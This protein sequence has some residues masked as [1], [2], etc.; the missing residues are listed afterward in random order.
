ME[1]SRAEVEHVA[2][3]AHLGLSPDEVDE[4][5]RE[6]SSVIGHVSAL[7]ALDTEHVQPTAHVLAIESVMREDVVTPS[8]PPEAVLANAP[9]QY[10][11]QF[12]V[13]AIFD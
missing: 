8:W 4:L 3:L 9:Q 12:E 10:E 13:Q 6:L 1:L 5:T 7:Q 11:N 2:R